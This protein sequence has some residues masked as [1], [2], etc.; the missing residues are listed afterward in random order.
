MA[1]PCFEMSPVDSPARPA[2]SCE[3]PLQRRRI[4]RA[5]F[6]DVTMAGIKGICAD[7]LRPRP[8]MAQGVPVDLSGSM[9]AAI[10]PD[11]GE[12]SLL[13]LQRAAIAL[14]RAKQFGRGFALYEPED[15]PYSQKKLVYLGG[16]RN[17]IELNQL[18]LHYQPKIDIKTK[19]TCGFEALLRWNHPVVGSAMNSS[20]CRTAGRF[21]GRWVLSET[22]A[23][24]TPGAAMVIFR[25]RQSVAAQFSIGA[26]LHRVVERALFAAGSS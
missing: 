8:F 22:I 13:L 25:L 17:A 20:Y 18:I 11:H 10:F 19:R 12:K 3:A 21:A 4:R 15:D 14:D 6:P 16:I 26:G 5:L 9:G 24:V 23:C 2:V 7:I 1:T